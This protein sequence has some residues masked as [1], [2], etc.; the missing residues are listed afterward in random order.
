VEERLFAHRRDLFTRLDLVF[1]DTTKDHRPDPRQMILTVV[2]DGD[3]RPVCSEMA[4]QHPD[5]MTLT[6]VIDRLR[7]RF[8]RACAWSPIAA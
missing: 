4:G 5:V 2:I 8:A 6:S 1:I 3:G 7:R